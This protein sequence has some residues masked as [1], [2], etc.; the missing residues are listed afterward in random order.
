[1]SCVKHLVDHCPSSSMKKILLYSTNI[2]DVFTLY[3]IDRNIE[4][5]YNPL[6]YEWV[7]WTSFQYDWKIMNSKI[8]NVPLVHNDLQQYAFSSTIN[9]SSNP[10]SSW[11]FSTPVV[12]TS[13]PDSSPQ[14]PFLFEAL[15]KQWGLNWSAFSFHICK[16]LFRC[17]WVQW[18][19]DKC[20]I[21]G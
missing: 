4:I 13:S 15:L 10:S 21:L 18:V 11:P 5:C 9:F 16:T 6:L 3:S 1:M 2:N 14:I 19:Q 12:S 7:H 8:T 20:L 17:L